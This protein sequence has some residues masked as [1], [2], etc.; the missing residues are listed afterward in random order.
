MHACDNVSCVA[1]YYCKHAID[2]HEKLEARDL[3]FPECHPC[4]TVKRKKPQPSY[5]KELR[6]V[7]RDNFK[8]AY[9]FHRF[10]PDLDAAVK[11]IQRLNKKHFGK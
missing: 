6:K 7:L 1:H 11:R 2:G 5:T 3:M 10:Q 4:R 9:K 8:Y